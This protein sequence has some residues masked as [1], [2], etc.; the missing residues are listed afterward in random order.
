M[1]GNQGHPYPGAHGVLTARAMAGW[2][3]AMGDTKPVSRVSFAR[4]AAV[5]ELAVDGAITRHLTSA[6]STS[7]STAAARAIAR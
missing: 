6:C 5:V 7:G 3:N 1:Q 2:R 4:Y